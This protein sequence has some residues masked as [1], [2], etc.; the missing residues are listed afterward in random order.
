[1]EAGETK[2][3]RAALSFLQDGDWKDDLYQSPDFSA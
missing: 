3:N 1:M 2:D